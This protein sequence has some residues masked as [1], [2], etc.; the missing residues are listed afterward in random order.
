MGV[1]NDIFAIPEILDLIFLSLPHL[2]VVGT[3]GRVCRSWKA[4]VDNPSPA[5]K[6]YKA[7]GVLPSQHLQYNNLKIT[8]A[9]LALLA[10]FWAKTVR[11]VAITIE[12][13]SELEI[14]EP[15]FWSWCFERA[16]SRRQKAEFQFLESSL[17]EGLH[18]HFASFVPI[19]QDIY[20]FFPA[21]PPYCRLKR[22]IDTT[23]FYNYY[24]GSR[25]QSY[26]EFTS[27]FLDQYPTLRSS[28]GNVVVKMAHKLCELAYFEALG[29]APRRSSL[30]HLINVTVT[31]GDW[32]FDRHK[33]GGSCGLNGCLSAGFP[34]RDSWNL[35]TQIQLCF[36]PTGYIR[37]S[38]DQLALQ[39]LF[40]MDDVR[41]ARLRARYDR[42]GCLWLVEPPKTFTFA[43][44]EIT[45]PKYKV[46]EDILG[47][48]R[49]RHRTERV[50]LLELY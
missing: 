37:D 5:L 43:G 22:P 23:S 50:Y 35:H 13:L 24:P 28:D 27:F 25:L 18:K 48:S 33:D 11:T 29:L 6:Y 1:S 46:D 40:N 7:T 34:P 10:L 39:K 16:Q 21:S 17:R 9:S 2:D 44:Q 12:S 4:A 49:R 42:R 3:V 38:Q 26:N 41:G 36:G 47:N 8:P 15:S 14:P 32:G 30:G 20:F 19:L 31:E 45:L